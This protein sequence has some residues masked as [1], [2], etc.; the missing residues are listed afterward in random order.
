MMIVRAAG[1]GQWHIGNSVITAIARQIVAACAPG[2]DG[3]MSAEIQTKLQAIR[4]K[5]ASPVKR[6]LNAKI[7]P[8]DRDTNLVDVPVQGT[9]SIFQ[10]APCSLFRRATGIHRA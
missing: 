6:M 4:M 3:P 9:P 5:G 2:A 7:V 8:L 10:F 1:R